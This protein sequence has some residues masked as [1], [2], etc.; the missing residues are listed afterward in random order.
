MSFSISILSGCGSSAA[1]NSNQEIS[2]ENINTNTNTAPAAAE[3]VPIFDNADTALAEGNKYFDA[4]ETGKAI[5]AYKQAVQLNAR[6]CRN[7]FSG[8]ASPKPLP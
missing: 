4:G 8:W 6:I 5:D 7:L 3:P 1:E 2:A